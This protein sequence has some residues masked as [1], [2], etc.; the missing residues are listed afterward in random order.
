MRGGV[1]VVDKP[2]GLTSHDVVHVVRR[3]MGHPRVGH[4]GTLDPFAT[5]VLPLVIGKATRLA[6][7]YAGADKEYVARIAL[8]WATDTYDGT[9]ERT[10]SPAPPEAIPCRGAIETALRA[11]V[12]PHDQVPPPYS[13][14]KSGGT[15]AYERARRGQLVELPPVRV[16]AHALAVTEAGPDEVTVQVHCSAGYYV[17]SLAHDLGRVLGIGA[18][19]ADLRR[20]RSGV[21]TLAESVGLEPVLRDPA[22]AAARIVPLEGLLMH[23]PGLTATEEGL[24][25]IQHGRPL[26]PSQLVG[27]LPAAGDDRVRLLDPEGRLVAVGTWQA[28]GLLH[29][30]LVLV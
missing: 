18:H 24:A 4:T 13:A 30:G 1:L 10:T 21:F 2:A 3:A 11:F 17:R 23:L 29:P 26:G 12:G 25:W 6:Q 16:T 5:G 27:P 19:L 7:F 15:P 20:T 28:G 8:G 9:G 14:K 22:V